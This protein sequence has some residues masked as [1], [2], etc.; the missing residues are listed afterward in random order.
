M[1]IVIGLLVLTGLI[2]LIFKIARGAA[3]GTYR[4][5]TGNDPKANAERARQARRN[6]PHRQELARLTAEREARRRGPDLG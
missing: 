4:A 5:V 1:E 6:S 2:G 3:R